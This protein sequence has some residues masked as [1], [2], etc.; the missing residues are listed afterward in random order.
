MDNYSKT[1]LKRGLPAPQP[2]AETPRFSAPTV[3]TVAPTKRH[4]IAVM[5]ETPYD[6]YNV[7]RELIDA[8]YYPSEIGWAQ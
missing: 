3:I 7:V 2:E 8:G 1:E 5:V 6:V 4:G